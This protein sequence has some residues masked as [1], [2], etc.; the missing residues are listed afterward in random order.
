[1]DLMNDETE[2]RDYALERQ[3]MLTDA[4]YAIALTLLTLDL[5]APEHWN[6][7]VATLWASEGPTFIAYLLSFGAIATF[8]AS[9]RQMSSHFR[10]TNFL[11]SAL[12]LVTLGLVALM[13]FMAKIYAEALSTRDPGE[14]P[15]LYL[16]VITGVAAGNAL[17]WGYCAIT[18]GLMTS[19]VGPAVKATVFVVL[20]VIPPVMSAFGALA[21]LPGL[22]W[23]PLAMGPVAAIGG[24]IRRWST[25]ADEKRKPPPEAAEAA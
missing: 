23:L 13:P 14:A 22:N 5:K 11:A 15:L 21:Y 8:W 18:P 3:M 12:A 6:H 16:S 4:V 7:S 2:M 9:Q 19:N 20:L 1:M 25:R 24:L 17:L 10:R